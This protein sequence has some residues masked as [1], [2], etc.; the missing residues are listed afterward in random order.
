MALTFDN[1]GYVLA[2]NGPGNTTE[3]TEDIGEDVGKGTACFNGEAG[4]NN[5]PLR[6]GKC[7]NFEG[8]IRANAFVSGGYLLKSVI[9]T[10]INEPIHI[11]DWYGTFCS[12]ADSFMLSYLHAFMLL[13]FYDFMPLFF[14]AFMLLCYYAFML[15]CFYVFVLLCIYVFMFYAF[16]LLYFYL[17]TAPFLYFTAMLVAI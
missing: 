14:Y 13:F 3:W 7:S 9:G 4:A 10:E 15:L 8:G 11:S 17:T 16:M 2:E 5:Y 1:G 12:M 6:G